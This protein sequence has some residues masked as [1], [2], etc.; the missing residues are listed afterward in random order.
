MIAVAIIVFREVLEAALI[1]SIVLA[2]SKGT[3]GRGRWISGGVALGVVGACLVAAFA[4]E[5]AAAVEGIGQELFNAAILFA[6]V[7][8][9]GWHNVWM[10]RHGKQMAMQASALGRD[11]ATGARP[12]YALALVVGIAVLR[13]GSETVLFLYGLAAAGGGG[14]VNMLGGGTIGVLGGALAGAALYLGLLRIPSRHLFA[15]TS[16]MILLLA[17]GLASQGAF[18][19]NQA[20]VLPALGNQIWDTSWLLSEDSVLGRV[21]HVLIGYVARPEGIQLVFWLATVLILLALMRWF[22]SAPPAAIA[23]S[24]ASAWRR[25]PAPTSPSTRRS[26]STASSKSSTT[27]PTPSTPIPRTSTTRPGRSSSGT[28]CCRGGARRWSSP[29]RAPRAIRPGVSTRSTGRT[30]FSWRTRANIA[31]RPASSRRSASRRASATRITSR[32]ARRSKRNGATPSTPSICSLSTCS[33]PTT[34]RRASISTM[35]GSRSGRGSGN[36][37]R[38]SRFSAMLARSTARPASAIS[39]CAPGLSPTGSSASGGASAN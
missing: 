24:A 12:P 25:S 26:S 1:V 15:V 36:S 9:L 2:A 38:A 33:V 6:A 32:S 11:V 34:T 18:F 19:L 28:A 37:S 3:A 35:L 13:E 4:T 39:S 17:A 10:G 20:D 5:I 21:L 23:R 27:A 31:S 7:G 30:P 8:M 29:G 16:W 22:S 14:L